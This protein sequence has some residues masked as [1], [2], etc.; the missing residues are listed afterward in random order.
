MLG[1]HAEN[2]RLLEFRYVGT[3]SENGV[4]CD[5]PLILAYHSVSEHR[6]DSLAVRVTDFENQMDWLYRHGY[7]SVNLAQ[8]ITRPVQKKKGRIVIITFDDGYA[9]N[10]TLAFPILKRYGFAAT[11]FLVSDYVNTDHLFSWDV[12]KVTDQAGQ[13]SYRLL[14]WEQ[15]HEMAAY[16]VEFGSHTCTHRELTSLPPEQC[17]E[18]I[19]RSR[20]DLQA[21]L[22]CEIVSFSYPRGD[23]N[24][25]VVQLVEKAGYACAVVTPPR[26]GIP[27]CRYALRRIGV[28]HQNSP[29]VFRLKLTHFVRRNYERFR[30]LRWGH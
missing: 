27:L 5:W 13:G 8:L 1:S 6:E 17:G 24:A 9:D 12:S 4:W 3:M 21:R 29:L 10:Y 15:V 18:E 22:G 26:S 28:Y 25:K 11:I 30:C 16:G 19:T 7:G 20:A 2:Q 14:T 23:L